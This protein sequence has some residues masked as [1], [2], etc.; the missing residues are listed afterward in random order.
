MNIVL[1]PEFINRLDEI[2]TFNELNDV[3]LV[4]ICHLLMKEIALRLSQQEIDM[5]F[6]TSLKN[7]IVSL[8]TEKKFGARPLK[9]LLSKHVENKISDF[10]LDNPDTTCVNVTAQKSEVL[11]TDC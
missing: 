6:T 8:N 7:Y 9:R 2:V 10:I 11:I 4:K 1:K 3:D 5:K